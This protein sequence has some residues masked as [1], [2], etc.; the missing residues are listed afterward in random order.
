[1]K[2]GRLPYQVSITDVCFSRDL[3]PGGHSFASGSML[4]VSTVPA[5]VWR[6]LSSSGPTGLPGLWVVPKVSVRTRRMWALQ[7]QA[8]CGETSV[9]AS[10]DS[11]SYVGYKIV[12]LFIVPQFIITTGFLQPHGTKHPSIQ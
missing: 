5:S 2:N 10:L 3:V 11:L 1:M 9:R 6:Q 7:T 8:G 12:Y 4:A